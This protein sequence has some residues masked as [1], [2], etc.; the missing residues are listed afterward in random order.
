MILAMAYESLSI[1]TSESSSGV[2]VEQASTKL[3][4]SADQTSKAVEV[5]VSLL[6]LINSNMSVSREFV[7]A[8][9]W[10]PSAGWIVGSEYAQSV[11][12]IAWQCASYQFSQSHLERAEYF[13]SK[14]AGGGAFLTKW[15][16]Y[17]PKPVVL[18]ISCRR[19]YISY[20][21]DY[22]CY[23]WLCRIDGVLY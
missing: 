6:S 16:V 11:Y 21:I 22:N 15:I 5:R 17:R 20:L 8:E 1:L 4:A 9:V 2:D 23:L 13:V 12:I 10:S 18:V 7:S 19:P 14:W 3:I